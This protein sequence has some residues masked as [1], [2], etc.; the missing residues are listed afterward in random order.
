LLSSGG[1]QPAFFHSSIFPPCGCSG[2]FG[3]PLPFLVEGVTT[4]PVIPIFFFFQTGCPSFLNSPWFFFGKVGCPGL[5]RTPR[6]R[7]VELTPLSCPRNRA[8]KRDVT[9][10]FTLLGIKKIA[11]LFTSC[12]APRLWILVYA[13]RTATVRPLNCFSIFGPPLYSF[14]IAKRRS[15]PTVFLPV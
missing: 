11:P 3:L 8:S 2:R 15:D 6:R 12:H 13:S 7:R 4:A 14:P 1:Q 9:V 5:I 10:Y